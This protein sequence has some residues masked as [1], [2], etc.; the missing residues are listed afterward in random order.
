[1]YLFLIN[2]YLRFWGKI[3]GKP[4]NYYILEAE[5]QADELARRLEVK[6]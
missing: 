5:L 2:W 3:L 4:K 1:M 6:Y